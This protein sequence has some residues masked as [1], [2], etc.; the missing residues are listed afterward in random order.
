MSN[1]NHI[2]F[3]SANLFNFIA[4][5]GAY[6]DFENIYSLDDWHDK[7]AWTKS[8]F[9]QLDP[10]VI[11]LQEVFSI[12]ETKAFFAEIGYEYFATVDTPHIEG[13]YIYSR[14]V[15]AVAS[16]FPIES[17]EAVTFDK[18]TLNSF[19]EID[20]PTFSRKPVRATI[21]HPIIGHLSVYVTHL[22]SQRPADSDTPEQASRP[23]ARW[24]STQQRGWEA[25][26]LRD[27]MQ[28]Q[29][30]LIPMPTVLMGDMNQAIT[31]T[32]VNNVLTEHY[33]D[34]VTDLQLNDGWELQM[35]P[36]LESRPATHY[37]FATGNVLDYILLSQEFD[38]HA[39]V[40]IAEV[41][42]Y[43][44]LDSHL[45]NPSFERDKNASDHAFVALTVEIKL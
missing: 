45:I 6:Y 33:G 13:D 11:G 2:T 3:A 38:A 20:A 30:A 32:S 15:V 27:A 26:M 18:E 8:Q 12:E 24:L 17:F 35:S 4:P 16:R 41:T 39:D 44:V 22:K 21:I 36:S 29:Y 40:S 43:Q 5:P 23:I 37:H 10:D 9:E 31:P 7:L 19:G 1:K 25:A 34:S 42:N 14:P 28:R